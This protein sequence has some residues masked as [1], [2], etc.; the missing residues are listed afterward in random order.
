FK[1]Y[2]LEQYEEILRK[3]K[4]LEPKEQKTLFDKDF[5]YIFSTDPKMLSAIELDYENNKIRVDLTKI[6]PEKQ[7]D[8]HE[9]LSNLKGK[10]IK[11]VSER[12]IEF[13]DGE[14]IDIKNLDYRSIKNLIWW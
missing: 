12:E 4:Y 2:E 8:I 9:T 3:A 13:Q 1:Y 10:W 14:K 11:R 7:I 5:N 6:Y